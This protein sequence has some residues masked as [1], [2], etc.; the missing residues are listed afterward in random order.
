[1]KKILIAAA[2]AAAFTTSAQAAV[3][4]S[5]DAAPL[6]YEMRGEARNGRSGF[7]GK[8]NTQTIDPTM[9]PGGAPVWAYGSDYNFALTYDSATG[10]TT[11]GID[12]SR[13]S[14]FADDQELVSVVDAALVGFGFNY[15]NLFIQGNAQS[16]VN[17]SNFTLNGTSFGPFSA[18]GSD[19][20]LNTLFKDTGGTFANI[21]ATG[22]FSFSANGA[23]DERPR[24]WVQVGD[25]SA[26]GAIP[27]PATWAMMIMG[28]GAA[29]AAIRRRRLIPTAA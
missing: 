20:A 5:G 3:V 18:G 6:S 2:A 26:V 4:V 17:V 22:S 9:N 28:F 29:G 11:W 23:S 10:T 14:D 25:K 13:D 1:M 24:L 16:L 21:N 15:V 7:E 27:E 19:T 8:L 12:F